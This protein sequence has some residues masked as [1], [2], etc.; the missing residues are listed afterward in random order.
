MAIANFTGALQITQ[1]F[2][3][4]ADRLKKVVAGT[5]F[6]TTSPNEDTSTMGLAN[7]S[8]SL[9]Q[10][11]ASFGVQNLF[12]ALRTMA[13]G[14]AAVPGRK[15]LILFTAGF[16]LNPD[17]M[18]ELTATINACNKANVAVYPIDV[19]GLIAGGLAPAARLPFLWAGLGR[20]LAVPSGV[21][22]DHPARRSRG[23][24]V[25][26]RRTPER[27][28][29]LTPERRRRVDW[30]RWKQSRGHRHRLRDGHG[31]GNR[32]RIR[33]RQRHWHRYGHRHWHRDGLGQRRQHR[34]YRRRRPHQSQSL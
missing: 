21:F 31:N 12:Y 14:L 8:T 20:P 28:W 17:G 3:P 11:A 24:L 5:K 27:R 19:R 4:D 7:V 18:S 1:N 32:H 23:F 30:R 26:R 10:A 25:R 2:T 33:F 22:C 34:H 13:K 6:S 16:H 9:S 15:S 29:R